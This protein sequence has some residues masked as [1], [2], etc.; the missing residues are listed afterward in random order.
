MISPAA[1]NN[2]RQHGTIIRMRMADCLEP[3][4][5]FMAAM[6][7][8]KP[9]DNELCPE[10]VL[11][12]DKVVYVIVGKM[13]GMLI[14]LAETTQFRIQKNELLIRVDD[15]NRETKF[16][17]REMVLRS[18]WDHAHPNLLV[19]DSEEPSRQRLQPAAMEQSNRTASSALPNS[20]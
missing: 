6:S 19:E 15:E 9:P 10:Y 12:S 18:E 7:G 11:V 3:Q 5:G 20:R 8:A 4:H 16:Q 14:P 1:D 2:Q 13:S 17:L